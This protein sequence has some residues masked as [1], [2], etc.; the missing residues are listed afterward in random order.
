MWVAL[1]TNA[2][3]AGRGGQGAAL[4][5]QP[6]RLLQAP[7]STQASRPVRCRV[8]AS[9]WSSATSRMIADR[10]DRKVAARGR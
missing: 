10:L 2:G 3:G 1:A 4:L 8:C 5:D 7:S 9:A 6:D